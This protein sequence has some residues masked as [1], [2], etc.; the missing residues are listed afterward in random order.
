M[1]EPPSISSRTSVLP[2]D[3]YRRNDPALPD[4]NSDCQGIIIN[5]PVAKVYA[6]CAQF[7]NL[8]RFIKSVREVKRIDPSRFACTIVANSKEVQ[9]TVQ[10]LLRVPERRI[11]WQAVSEDF[12]I[13]VILFEPQ[14]NDTTMVTVKVRSLVEPVTLTGALRQ[15]LSSFKR[16]MEEE[17]A[18]S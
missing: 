13:G 9:S 7:E 17:V 11:A 2:N 1:H 3:R 18:A 16:F 10:V 12:R 8:P 6:H 4:V 14:P 15:H 5:A